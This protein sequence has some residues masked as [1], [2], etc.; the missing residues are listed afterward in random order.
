MPK[1]YI[2]CLVCWCAGRA[3]LVTCAFICLMATMPYAFAGSEFPPVGSNG[4]SGFRE[5]CP[6]GQY[7]VGARYRAG[8]WLDQIS[9]TCAPVDTIGLTG[10]QWHGSAFGG[11]GGNPGEKSCPPGYISSGALLLLHSGNQF[12]HYMALSCISTVKPSQFSSPLD[13][14][15][16]SSLFGDISQTCPPGEAVTGIQ[17]RTGEF[18]DAIGLICD[19]FTS[20]TPSNPE[21]PPEVCL[22]LKEEQVPEQWKDMLD[23]HNERRKQHCVAPLTW[24]NELAAK[25]QEY[26]DQC[27]LGEHGSNGE[28]MADAWT[29]VNGAPVLPALSDREAFENTWYCEVNNY[30]FNNPRFKGGFTSQCKDVNGHFTQVVWKDTCQLGCGRATCAIK[31]AQGVVHSGTHWVCR[32][33]PPGNINTD[34]V[35][36]L[37]HQVHAPLCADPKG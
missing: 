9:I 35:N 19:A 24:S 7:V 13:I 15:A 30:D 11:Q 10:P 17:G 4:G 28:N 18:V 12:V 22:G 14:G 33:R 25:A 5:E 16:P 36:V 3:K 34:N 2:Q 27:I 8:N 6:S 31:D 26:A 29:N 37:K 32:Y 20:R 1:S 23:A 21:R